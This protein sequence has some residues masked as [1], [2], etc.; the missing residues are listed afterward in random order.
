MIAE[1]LTYVAVF[2]AMLA[3]VFNALAWRRKP[4]R[5]WLYVLG[6]LAAAWVIASYAAVLMGVDMYLLTCAADHWTNGTAK[7]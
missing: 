1:I 7:W 3:L 6:M 2:V 5:K 4:R